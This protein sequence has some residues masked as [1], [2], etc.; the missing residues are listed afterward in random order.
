MD[1]EFQVSGFMLN[2][3][4][5]AAASNLKP[6]TETL[7]TSRTTLHEVPGSDARPSPDAGTRRDSSCA[8]DSGQQGLVAIIP[9]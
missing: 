8:N 9:R 6:L 7:H 5:Y 4:R 2:V 1:P 3:S